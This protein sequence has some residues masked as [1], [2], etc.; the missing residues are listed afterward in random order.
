[1]LAI[2]RWVEFDFWAILHWIDD[3]GS[4]FVILIQLNLPSVYD[5]WNDWTYSRHGQN[6]VQK[7]SFT[8]TKMFRYFVFLASNR[9]WNKNT[10]LSYQIRKLTTQPIALRPNFENFI[11]TTSFQELF[12]NMTLHIS[13]EANDVGTSTKILSC[14][15]IA[16]RSNE[17]SSRLID[18]DT[19]LSTT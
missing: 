13:M 18:R 2:V 16:F 9:R 1:M 3:S 12:P 5:R 8:K 10:Y 14:K 19:M 17:L 15:H 11:E 4:C 7:G 6:E